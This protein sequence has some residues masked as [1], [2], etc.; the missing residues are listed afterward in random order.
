MRTLMPFDVLAQLANAECVL[1]GHAVIS[2][3]MGMEHCAL[4]GWSGAV[5]R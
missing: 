1:K 2:S 4:R 5:E 3:G